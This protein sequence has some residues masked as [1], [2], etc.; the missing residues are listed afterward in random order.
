MEIFMSGENNAAAQAPREKER[1]KR[2]N[3]NRE[4]ATS[5]LSLIRATWIEVQIEA[6]LGQRFQGK[7]EEEAVFLHAAIIADDRTD[8][9]NP[10]RQIAV[11]GVALLLQNARSPFVLFPNAD[12]PVV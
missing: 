4:R 2:E 5:L 3:C 1:A 10:T 9:R 8:R 6:E 11:D 12:A 7:G